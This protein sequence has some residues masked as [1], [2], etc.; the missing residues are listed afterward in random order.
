[1]GE[2]IFDVSDRHRA[3][4]G[5]MIAKA[6][7]AGWRDQGMEVDYDEALDYLRIAIGRTR[8]S[9]AFELE[10]KAGSILLYDPDTYVIVG[11]E[12]PLFIGKFRKGLLREEFWTLVAD[13]IREHGPTVYFAGRSDSE[14]AGRAFLELVPA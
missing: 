2:N 10:D 6:N 12:V 1:V 8:E 13:A 3:E 5:S 14:R 11:L 9:L 7:Q 4:I